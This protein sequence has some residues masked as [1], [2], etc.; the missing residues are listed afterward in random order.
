[1]PA[2]GEAVKANTAGVHKGLAAEPIQSA[3]VLAEDEGEKRELE[4]MRKPQQE[5][6]FVPADIGVLRAVNHKAV[7]GEIRGETV[8][9]V[10]AL[11]IRLDQILGAAIQPILA[12]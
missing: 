2:V 1:L 12:D 4:R 5:A 7:V 8:I 10:L 9:V 11:A 3:V 6:E